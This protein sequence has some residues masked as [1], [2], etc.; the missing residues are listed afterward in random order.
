MASCEKKL[1]SDR[2]HFGWQSPSRRGLSVSMLLQCEQNESGDLLCVGHG[3]PPISCICNSQNDLE[4]WVLENLLFSQFKM[5]S[6]AAIVVNHIDAFMVSVYCTLTSLTKTFPPF[7]YNL[8]FW[9]K[10]PFQMEKTFAHR[11]S[12]R[13]LLHPESTWQVD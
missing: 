5:F 12:I 2:A 11:H 10:I 9:Y 13:N 6:F 4:G 8:E 7:P 3:A 1:C